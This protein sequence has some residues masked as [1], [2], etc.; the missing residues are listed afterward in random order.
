MAARGL[1]LSHHLSRE[2]RTRLANPM[3]ET[4]RRVSEAGPT[5]INLGNGNPVPRL[6][7]V[8]AFDVHVSLPTKS[9]SPN[10]LATPGNGNLQT[11]QLVTG[12]APDT[13]SAID[14]AIALQYSSGRGIDKAIEVVQQL[15]EVLHK[16]P[17][18][19]VIM[20]SGSIDALSK[21]FRMFCD[22]GDTILCEEF[23]FPGTINAPLAM[24]VRW[25]PVRIDEDGIIPEE[26]ESVLTMWD[27]K[28]AGQNPTG[29]TLTPERRQRI[30][31]LAQQH[32]LLILEDVSQISPSF[33]SLDVDGRVL[34]IDTLSK[35]L[36]P[37][38]RLGWITC[39]QFFAEKLLLLTDSTTQ[40]ANGFSQAILCELF[41]TGR[42]WGIDGYITWCRGLRDEYQRRRD[43]LMSV[44]S[45]EVL[46]TGLASTHVPKAG[47]FFWVE[48]H[49][50]KHRDIRT[51][52]LMQQLADQVFE[53][54][55]MVIPAAPFAVVP[56][57]RVH[58]GFEET[59]DMQPTRLNHLRITFAPEDDLI[60]RGIKV[61]GE[62]LVD[63]FKQ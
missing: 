61:L 1:D 47:M 34:R 60:E 19:H 43:V 30:Y 17:H 48:I 39:T 33:L 18:N 52:V 24:G 42:G 2:G 21:C 9:H 25:A 53:R 63:F 36:V 51:M 45:K 11:L 62:V 3:K 29:S 16:P 32:D 22:Q 7:A 41:T 15:N 8:D 20:T 26:L 4:F 14:L 6:F 49:V 56:A 37:G 54:N 13:R 57:Y 35:T 40:H 38:M 28:K 50:E 12:G 23:S 10:K 5:M 31:K 44:L 46:S 58:D 27:E 55:V 59:P